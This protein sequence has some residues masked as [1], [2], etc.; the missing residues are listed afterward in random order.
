MI[1]GLFETHI[2]VADLERSAAFYEEI[3]GLPL[4]HHEAARRANFY[5][6]GGYGKAMLGVWEV[7]PAELRR[8]HFAFDTD[9]EGFKAAIAN[10]KAKGVD[11]RNFKG[12]DQPHLY[13]I[14]WM[15]AVSIYFADPDGH[16][17][18]YL[19]MLPDEPRPD[20][21]LVPWEEWEQL[22]GR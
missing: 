3:L 20:L 8:E 22:H 13:V 1:R 16:S 14:A 19:T 6:L 2:N 18:E 11:T 21:G 4:G 5:W 7:D 9:M 12:D 17:L 15:P 10:L